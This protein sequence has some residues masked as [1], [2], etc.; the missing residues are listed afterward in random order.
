M[1]FHD[2]F[3]NR[4]VS[5]IGEHGFWLFYISMIVAFRIMLLMVPGLDMLHCSWSVVHLSHSAVGFVL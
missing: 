1:G 5:F 4:N 2:H 3:E